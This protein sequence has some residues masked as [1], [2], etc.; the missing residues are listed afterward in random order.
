[1][2]KLRISYKWHRLR[3]RHDIYGKEF[4]ALTEIQL[5]TKHVDS[6]FFIKKEDAYSWLQRRVDEDELFADDDTLI[7][8][9]MFF[10]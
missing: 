5:D 10:T 4:Q 6:N 9:E 7:L 3:T 2:K 1:M 8:T